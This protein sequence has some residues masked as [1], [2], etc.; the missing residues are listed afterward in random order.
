MPT[1]SDAAIR[2]SVPRRRA[3]LLGLLVLG[4][5]VIAVS[6]V[7]AAVTIFDFRVVP[8]E[9]EINAYWET[10]SEYDNLGFYIL[11][12]ESGGDAYEKL[13]L[14][15]PPATQIT[16]SEDE[17]AGASY[18][19]VDVQVTPG[20][21]YYYLVQGV[22]ENGSPGELVGPKSAIIELEI[23][24]PTP[25]MTPTPVPG[26]TETPLPEPSVR[27]WADEPSLDAGDCATIQWQTENVQTVFFD[28]TAVTGQ[29]AQTFCPCETETYTL[30]VTYQDDTFEDF[31]VQLTVSGTCQDPEP[32]LSVLATPTSS[33]SPAP[34]TATPIP[35][36]ATPRPA[37]VRPTSTVRP[38]ST[39]EA[40][41]V[42]AG[43]LLPVTSPL[44]TPDAPPD[45]GEPSDAGPG[46]ESVAAPDDIDSEDVGLVVEGVTVSRRI[47]P[48]LL[49]VA[50]LLG[51]G[52]LAGGILLWRR[53]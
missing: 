1:K 53:G 29:G 12:R 52:S 9:Q 43:S 49:V 11:R 7:W 18:E 28:G 36:S 6:A 50:G 39:P 14:D 15:V 37:Q 33:V 34:Q 27:F 46:D 17:L 23:A 41:R 51:M 47:P 5:L 25:T 32:S 3:C 26:A 45:L 22:S 38:R 13:P 8:G 16:P 40:I 19:F 4:S 21:R 48:V 24:T 10:A 20:I 2:R 30:S 42:P 35:A 44:D 31:T